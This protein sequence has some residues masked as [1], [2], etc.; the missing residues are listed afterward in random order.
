MQI[1]CAASLLVASSAGCKRQA[2]GPDA[3]PPSAASAASSALAAATSPATAGAA[4]APGSGAS[5]TGARPSSGCLPDLREHLMLTARGWTKDA[6]HFVFLS[7]GHY[8]ANDF[9]DAH[10]MVVREAKTGADACYLVAVG[11][12]DLDDAAKAR[13]RPLAPKALFDAWLAEH[14]LAEEADGKNSP[15]GTAT[16]GL[17]TEPG[18]V[19][20]KWS[21]GAFDYVCRGVGTQ[22]GA[23]IEEAPDAPP[24]GA[25]LRFF[26]QRGDDKYFAGGRTVRAGNV[27]DVT[28]WWSADGRRVAWVHN[29]DDRTAK[30][31]AFVEIVLQELPAPPPAAPAPKAN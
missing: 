28:P 8:T 24:C 4:T 14:P 17:D 6:S 12:L 11:E 21:E 1:T 18:R 26:V 27:G 7:E 20:G 30:D 29:G 10:I 31:G 13:L 19:A 25:S 5:K 2:P 15:D 16:A 23:Q 3:G 22:P 9:S